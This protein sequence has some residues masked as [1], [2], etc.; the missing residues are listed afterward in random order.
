MNATVSIG[1]A[2]QPADIAH[3]PAMLARADRALYAAKRNGR[4]RI[5]TEQDLRDI[6]RKAPPLAPD[7]AASNEDCGTMVDAGVVPA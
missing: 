4:N 6:E 2:E 3:I 5:C 1:I 7:Y